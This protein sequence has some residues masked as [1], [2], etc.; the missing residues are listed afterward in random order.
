M[1]NFRRALA[2]LPYIIAGLL[3]SGCPQLFET[4]DAPALAGEEGLLTISLSGI[5]VG[6]SP[7][8]TMLP[9]NP[10]FTR[11]ELEFGDPSGRDNYPF[12]NSTVQ[13]SLEAGAYTI[14]VWGYVEDKP[15]AK[16]DPERVT[17][18]SGGFTPA[19]FTLKPFMDD[20]EPG[21]LNYSLSWDGL[22]RMPN[23]AELL[24]ETY[25]EK[26]PIAS[27]AILAPGL[28]AAGPGTILLLQRE[29]AFVNL[30]GSLTL[31]PGEYILTMT[32]VMD[33]GSQPVSRMDIAHV[34]SNL[35]TAGSFH[36]G[37][38]DLFVSNTSPDSGSAFI[39]GFTFAETPNATTVIGSVPG[40]DGTRLIM[41]MVPPDTNLAGLT[42]LVETAEGASITSPLPQS[43]ASG[44]PNPFYGQGE[45]DFTNP[46]VWTAQ[47]KNGAVQQYTVVVST[48]AVT[49]Q[50]KSITYFFFK[51]YANY[52]GIIDQSAAAITVTLPYGTP[53]N[54]LTPIIS[55]I[56]QKVLKS[57]GGALGADSFS[58][59]RG[60]KVYATENDPSP[61]EYTVTVTVAQ[62]NEAEIVKFVI[63]GYPDVTAVID[64]GASGEAGSITAELPYGVSLANLSPLIQYKGKTLEPGS[65]TP[66]NF[67]V[68]VS[69]AVSAENGTQKTYQ[70]K[71]TN[72]S[73]DADTGIFDFVITNVPA[74]KVVIGQKPRA[75]G[76][77]PIVI[78]VPY[79][80][81]EKNLIPA[82]T[83][84][85]PTS[86]IDP[87][88]G[89]AIPFGNAD[90]NQEAVYTVTA[91]GGAVQ[92]YVVVVSAGGQY[93]YVNGVTGRDDWPDYYNGGSES[94]PF[95]TL[96]YA[97]W[98]TSQDAT[99][100]R[101]FVN[102][103]LNDSTEGGA[104][105]R[106]SDGASGFRSGGGEAGSV[107]NLIGTGK[108]ITITGTSNATLRGTG[109]KRVLSITGGAQLVFENI[110]IIGGNAPVSSRNGNGGG[111]YISENSRVKFLDGSITEN[112]AGNSG[113]GVFIED[114]GTNE[115]EF[116]LAGSSISGN[117][118]KGKDTA[119]SVMAGGG[120]VYV[121]GNA[122]VWLG[123]GTIS[124][125][126]ASLGAGGG[127][128]INCTEGPNGEGGFLMS[129]GKIY[130]NQSLSRTYPHGGGGVYAAQGP[131]EMLG[132]EITGNTA[133][134][135]G[136][137]VF[138][139]WN[140]RLSAS[141]NS[142][143]SGNTGVGSSAA[144]CNRGITEMMGNAQ[145]DKVYVWNYDDDKSQQQ[146]FVI[147]QNARVGGIVLAY[148]VSNSNFLTI[149]EN[150]SGTDQICT[151]DLEGHL[152][153]SGSFVGDLEP[154]WLNKKIIEGNLS[155]SGLLDRLPL[156]TFVGG[157][158]IS[159]MKA[160]YRIQI[161]G[162]DGI[163]VRR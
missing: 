77:I 70:V 115:G 68:P 97:V 140:A 15:V 158:T 159:N 130:G 131:F 137:G 9:L 121:K 42:P 13:L 98:K 109:S 61:K 103:E 161:N 89:K 8:R 133:N 124:G 142:A 33:A 85:S 138:V 39:T 162:M 78:Q 35:T 51:N 45:I 125:N 96:A 30:N 102:G 67:N 5:N 20:G 21:V 90:N 31:P 16:S 106:A 80:T 88:S 151:I 153:D 86:R 92:K 47:A 111:I 48:A 135:Q 150:P 149:Y 69:Y 54:S 63:D 82:I 116:T 136:G 160:R 17:V 66:Q 108:K 58:S 23:R 34:Y 3:L 117:T 157:E 64:Q 50:E 44:D 141:G 112:T 29:T 56:G 105:E 73:G 83:L 10:V 118:A 72:K 32:V 24:I 18:S 145:A 62:N 143:I 139:H 4:P 81:D 93:Y 110:T 119:L 94:Y 95:K 46:S 49:D 25:P 84:R 144:I 134:R 114:S 126:T 127:V 148:S 19:E 71:L 129:G 155:I 27:S 52:P 22:S 1:K 79:M 107:F 91:Q 53:L 87:V 11:Y 2:V 101:I 132:G 120:G 26:E 55:I 100:N 41:I 65:G 75:D 99:I 28:A 113:G 76:K 59:P 36:Y 14:T 152:N 123:S 43:A 74:A 104:W 163:M 7:S 40:T 37:G 122:L 12:Y 154:D 146:S 128:L 38:G 57:D 60:F 147:A 6:S 156:G